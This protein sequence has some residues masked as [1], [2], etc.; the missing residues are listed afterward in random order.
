MAGEPPQARH[1]PDR[2]QSRVRR[3]ALTPSSIMKSIL[4][5]QV[6]RSGQLRRHQLDSAAQHAAQPPPREFH[7]QCRAARARRIPRDR[8]PVPERRQRQLQH[9]RALQR[10]VIHDA[11]SYAEYAASRGNLALDKLN[12]HRDPSAQHA[13]PDFRRASVAC[14]ISPRASKRATRP[15]SR[16]SAP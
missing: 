13:G 5:P 12:L 15:S 4:P 2:L 16:T 14:R 7:R 1:L 6:H 9:A 11:D 8:L 10:S 3:A